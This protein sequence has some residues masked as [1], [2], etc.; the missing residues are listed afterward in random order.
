MFPADVAGHEGLAFSFIKKALVIHFI[1]LDGKWRV[2]QYSVISQCDFITSI[3]KKYNDLTRKNKTKVHV[4]SPWRAFES[5][6]QRVLWKVRFSIL[7]EFPNCNTH[8]HPKNHF[9]FSSWNSVW[10]FR[11][12]TSVFGSPHGPPG[13]AMCIQF[14]LN[15]DLW[16]QT[17]LFSRNDTNSSRGA[18]G[19]D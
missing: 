5:T 7:G 8:T 6:L 10:K 11:V 1:V 4:T 12:H 3:L 15:S 9:L 18:W 16:T 13:Y 19:M 14:H 17:L 2:F